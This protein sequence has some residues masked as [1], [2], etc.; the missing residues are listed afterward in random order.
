MQIIETWQSDSST[1]NTPMAIKNSVPMAT[2]PFPVPTL[3]ILMLVIF[4]LKNVQ[5]GHK[6]ICLLD[7]AYEV[8]LANIKM[9]CQRWPKKLL[10]W[11]GLQPSMLPW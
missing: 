2:H 1:G 8:L 9:E 6:L 5:Q 3:L 10:I 7:H 11:G 4:S